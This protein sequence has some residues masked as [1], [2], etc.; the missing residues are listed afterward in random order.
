MTFQW[1]PF[2]HVSPQGLVRA[3]YGDIF[4]SL[5][6]LHIYGD[7]KEFHLRGK[8]SRLQVGLWDPSKVVEAGILWTVALSLSDPASVC[9][10]PFAIP[11]W[12][13]EIM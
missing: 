13:A 7:P 11:G 8:N 3:I 9:H 5:E 2:S 4:K 12:K 6:S 10:T 1:M